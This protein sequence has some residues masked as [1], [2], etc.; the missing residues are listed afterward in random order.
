MITIVDN[1]LEKDLIEY[2]EELF[3]Y[4]TPHFY[5]HTSNKNNKNFSFYSSGINTEDTLVSFIIK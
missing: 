3:V 4:K 2:L 5:G 1:F